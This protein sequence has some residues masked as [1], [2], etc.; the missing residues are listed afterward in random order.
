MKLD[1]HLKI[2]KEYA[3]KNEIEMSASDIGPLGQT[4]NDMLNEEEIG[5]ATDEIISTAIAR[6]YFTGR[7]EGVRS[8]QEVTLNNTLDLLKTREG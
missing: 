3:K 5:L 2:C 8:S 1:D 4:Y 7:K 6:G